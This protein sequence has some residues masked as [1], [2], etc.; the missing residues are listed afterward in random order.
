MTTTVTTQALTMLAQEAKR[1]GIEIKVEFGTN[2]HFATSSRNPD[3]LYRV[4]SVSCTC[5]G[6]MQWGR[7]THLAALHAEK[8]W[9]PPDDDDDP[10]PPVVPSHEHENDAPVMPCPAWDHGIETIRTRTDKQRRV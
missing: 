1:R 10:D 9:L 5:P 6:F 2:A 7:C 8:G 3:L 4:T